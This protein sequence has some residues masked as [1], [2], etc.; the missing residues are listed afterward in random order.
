MTNAGIRTL[1]VKIP[2]GNLQIDA[3]LAEPGNE[4]THPAVIVIQEIFGVNIHIRDVTE[5]LAKEGY[6]AIAQETPLIE[7]AVVWRGEEEIPVLRKFLK[8]VI[9]F[10]PISH[11]KVDE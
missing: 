10:S 6:V 3:Y 2:N 5:R 4:G 8:V 9:P 1:N 11:L 7:T